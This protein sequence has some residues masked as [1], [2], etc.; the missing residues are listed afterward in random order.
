MLDG[1]GADAELLS[2]GNVERGQHLDQQVTLEH[3]RPK[4]SSRQKI[5][6][7]AADGGKCT[8]NGRIHIHPM[9]AGSNA[10]LSNKNIGLGDHATI[11]TKPELEIY[12]DDV[13]CAHGATIGRLSKDELFYLTSRGVSQ[14]A[15]A[16]LLRRAFL[17]QCIHGPLAEAALTALTGQHDEALT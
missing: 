2:A 4:G 6:N 17:R 1:E 13:S 7:I 5:H 15:A 9:A 16:T 14:D 11:N 3:R 8:F 10:T 12:N